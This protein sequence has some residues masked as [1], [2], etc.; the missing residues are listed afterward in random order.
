MHYGPS[1]PQG[2]MLTSLKKVYVAS[3]GV[4]SPYHEGGAPPLIP[5]IVT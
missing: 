5:P 1:S 4:A 3:P 2:D